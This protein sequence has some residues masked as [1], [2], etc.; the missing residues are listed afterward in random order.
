MPIPAFDEI[1]HL[2]S[3]DLYETM[4]KGSLVRVSVTLHCTHDRERNLFH[5]VAKLQSIHMIRRKL[6]LLA[7]QSKEDLLTG[8]F[9]SGY[10]HHVVDNSKLMG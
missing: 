9:Q 1:G 6:K 5:F 10:V 2:I 3:P 4:L 7:T 8:I